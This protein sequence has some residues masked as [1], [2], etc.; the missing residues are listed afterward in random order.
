MDL[1]KLKGDLTDKVENRVKV[2]TDSVD[3]DAFRQQ[4]YD[5]PTTADVTRIATRLKE[6]TAEANALLDLS[7]PVTSVDASRS[8]R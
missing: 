8:A 7:A 6:L 1:A 4:L 2:D 3:I 5:L